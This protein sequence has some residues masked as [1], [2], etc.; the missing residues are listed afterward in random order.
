MKDAVDA[1][2]P[3]TAS[4]SPSADSDGS[5][6]WEQRPKFEGEYST[7]DLDLIA[8]R[9]EDL[10]GSKRLIRELYAPFIVVGPASFSD[11][12]GS[13]RHDG[14]HKLRPHLGQD[15]FCEMDAEVLAT[16]PGTIEFGKDSLGG[17]IA[18]LHHARGGYWYYAH[19]SRFAEDL[20][21][22]DSV[23]TGDVIGYC[24]NTGNASGGFP[25]VHFG[26]Y[27]GPENPAK[28]LIGWLRD[29]EREAKHELERLID[30]RMSLVAAERLFGEP[31]LPNPSEVSAE[32]ARVE[33]LEAILG[34][35]LGER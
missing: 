3:G 5:V 29:A 22:G 19:L 10:F 12:W 6:W 33:E 1:A 13:I 31:F 4:P 20:E 9:V 14:A 18:R 21:S 2:V 24:G 15:V 27:P 8:N 16:E 34:I 35:A 17:K 32:E 7:E 26:S 25:H 11:T 28:D 30:Q 23:E